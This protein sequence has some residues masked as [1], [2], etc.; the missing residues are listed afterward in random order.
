MKAIRSPGANTASQTIPVCA[1][2]FAMISFT[3]GASL[4]KRLFPVVGAEGATTL[5]L[6]GAAMV[7]LVVLRPWR[8]GLRAAAMGPVIIYGLAMAAMNLLFYMALKT[9]PLGI[10][11][12]LEISGPMAISVLSSRAAV[13]LL[14]IGLAAVGLLLLLPVGAGLHHI[15]PTGAALALSAG[16]CWAI[17]IVAG[18]KAG[19]AYGAKAT[20]IGMSI[21]AIAIL[22]IG[23]AHSGASLLRPDVLLLGFSVALL[24]SALPYTLEMIA[25]RRLR[26]QTY[27]TLTS[28]EP[29]VGAISGLVL[30]NETLAFSQVLAIGVIVVAAAGATWTAS[31][32]RREPDAEV[33][34]PQDWRETAAAPPDPPL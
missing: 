14:W 22:P 33:N 32:T 34:F 29:A 18:K 2:L 11:V 9:V 23:I 16:V 26:V 3:S 4:A 19:R 31:K 25:L 10:A 20:S 13:D 1:L 28:C 27:G 6:I 15:D 17:Y 30:L 5:R 8:G 24:S 21:G 12:A 7:L